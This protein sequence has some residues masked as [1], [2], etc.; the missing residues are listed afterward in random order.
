MS[1]VSP[2]VLLILAQP[3]LSSEFTL[4]PASERP[5]KPVVLVHDG[6]FSVL[7]PSDSSVSVLTVAPGEQ[8]PSRSTRFPFAAFSPLA[9]QTGRVVLVASG[10]RATAG[11]PPNMT[12]FALSASCVAAVGNGEFVSANLDVPV[13]RDSQTFTVSRVRSP[14]DV[15]LLDA[16]YA[17]TGIDTTFDGPLCASSN[18]GAHVLS[19]ITSTFAM[20]PGVPELHTVDASG[21]T[22]VTLPLTDRLIYFGSG[23]SSV[24]VVREDA[25]NGPR[26]D[27]CSTTTGAC[28]LIGTPLSGA[29]R[30]LTSAVRDVGGA[31]Q[32]AVIGVAQRVLT[33]QVMPSAAGSSIR[34]DAGTTNGLSSAMVRSVGLLTMHQVTDDGGTVIK[35]RWINGGAIG[36]PCEANSHCAGSLCQMN[37]CVG[38]VVDGGLPIDEDAGVDAGASPD[39]GL[40]PDAGG[41]VD[42]GFETDAG[43]D[44]GVDAVDGGITPVHRDFG[45]GCGCDAA[46]SSLLVLAALALR[47]RRGQPAAAS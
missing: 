47:R 15:E 33:A 41:D 29:S 24:L 30:L 32:Y 4:V 39:A 22:R 27:A 7:Y 26:A 44:A 3:I 25:N 13:I 19:L 23:L 21:L 6:A 46:P 14:N 36:D 17:F 18:A 45:V 34:L 31:D 8:Q 28:Q 10:D 38:V 11:V 2:L 20:S 37:R 43:V 16:G 5:G 42:A 1:P 12:S 9:A 40:E 35:A